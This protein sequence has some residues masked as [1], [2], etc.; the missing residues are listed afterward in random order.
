MG[1]WSRL[2]QDT[3]SSNQKGSPS[4]QALSYLA[5][6]RSKHTYSWEIK[7]TGGVNSYLVLYRAEESTKRER[8]LALNSW[9][10]KELLATAFPL[11]LKGTA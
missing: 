4:L 1:Y 2:H 9:R 5:L 8:E 3:I 6:K 11:V 7:S 10:G